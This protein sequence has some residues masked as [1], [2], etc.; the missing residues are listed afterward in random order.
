MRN[1]VEGQLGHGNVQEPRSSRSLTS[2][3]R[4]SLTGK[5]ALEK[6]SLNVSMQVGACA[7][8]MCKAEYTEVII[9]TEIVHKRFN[10]SF[11]HSRRVKNPDLFNTAFITSRDP[12]ESEPTSPIS[13]CTTPRAWLY[14]KHSCFHLKGAPSR[15]CRPACMAIHDFEGAPREARRQ[16]WRGGI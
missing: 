3:R 1:L 12:P 5:N 7:T 11:R 6:P 13:R 4:D 9:L 8:A 14:S 15:R 16:D 2:R 10:Q